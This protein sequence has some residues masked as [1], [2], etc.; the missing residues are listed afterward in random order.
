[1]T[2]VVPPKLSPLYVWLLSPLEKAATTF[3]QQ[4]VVILTVGGA[5]VA[6]LLKQDWLQA[7]D[8]AGFA[9][10]ISILATYVLLLAQL[11]TVLPGWLDSLLGI[12]K[13]FIA[14]LLGSLTASV[15]DPS[16][17][18]APWKGALAVAI[19]VT[20]LAVLKVLATINL[21]W[22]LGPSLMPA[23]YARVVVT[24]KHEQH[25]VPAAP[26][27]RGHAPGQHG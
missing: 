13:T 1:M 17:I 23:V 16:V 25:E 4:F 8:T 7:A 12:V 24:G 19:P 5:T 21:P 3:V 10:L 6:L 9:A 15:V 2:T 18:H 27:L 14:S 11:P 26:E 22:T 20:L